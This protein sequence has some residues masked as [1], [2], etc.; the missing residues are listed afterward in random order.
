[1]EVKMNFETDHLYHVFN[2]GNNGERIFFKPANYRYFADKVGQYVLPYAD[3]VSWCF[4]P[5][6][7][8]FM[9]YVRRTVVVKTTLNSS[10]GR[11]LCTYARAVNIQ[12]KRT[13]S[14]FQQHTKAICL[15]KIHR[16]SP[17]WFK[18]VGITRL[19]MVLDKDYYPNTCMDYIHNN[20][21]K[22]GIVQKPEE[23]VW[24]SYHEIYTE[25]PIIHLINPERLKNVVRL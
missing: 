4:M 13:G 16:I 2:R 11:M 17:S 9:I 6:H 7:F 10:I 3:I 1:M 21:V 12:E 23:W 24:S 22:A 15:D 18:V 20:P 25:R 19:N 5:N 14:L 8:H